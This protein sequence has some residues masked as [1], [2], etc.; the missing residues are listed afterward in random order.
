MWRHE[1]EICFAERQHRSRFHLHNQDELEQ[2]AENAAAI[3]SH[4]EATLVAGLEELY[5][6]APEWWRYKGL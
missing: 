1:L 4:L 6:P 3:V 5:G 2:A